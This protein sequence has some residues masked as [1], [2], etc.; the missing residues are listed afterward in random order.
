MEADSHDPVSDVKRFFDTI[1]M[2]NVDI[3][4]ENS[5]MVSV[6]RL[7]AKQHWM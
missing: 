7:W 2:M 4:I 5:S 1:A 3:D 6:F